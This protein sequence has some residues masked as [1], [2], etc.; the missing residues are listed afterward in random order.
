MFVNLDFSF[1]QKISHSIENEMEI[2]SIK[3]ELK[4]E[5]DYYDQLNIQEKVNVFK[6]N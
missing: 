4:C 5:D 1:W 6:C 2:I 3:S